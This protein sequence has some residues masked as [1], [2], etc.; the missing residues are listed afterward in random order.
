MLK[1]PEIILFTLLFCIVLIV[2]ILFILA[3]IDL[4]LGTNIGPG[5][6]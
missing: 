4:F 1:I 6:H 2:S 5:W 3:L